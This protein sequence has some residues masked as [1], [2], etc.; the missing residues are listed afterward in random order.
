MKETRAVHILD[1]SGGR[2][3]VAQAAAVRVAH[4]FV[5]ITGAATAAQHGIGTGPREE[6]A[7]WDWGLGVGGGVAGVVEGT[8]GHGGGAS[9]PWLLL[10]FLQNVVPE[11]N[12]VCAVDRLGP[13][14]V[15]PLVRARLRRPV[16]V[17]LPVTPPLPR[18]PPLLCTVVELCQ[19][20]R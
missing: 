8:R 12:Q 19:R 7:T 14:V 16:Q 20:T 13:L 1:H 9:F 18:D 11:R 3:V 17:R 5:A 15:A 4:P 2:V 6:H 10:E